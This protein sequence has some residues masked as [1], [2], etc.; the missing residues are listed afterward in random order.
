MSDIPAEDQRLPSARVKKLFRDS[1]ANQ[2]MRISG[3]AT[4]V[5]VDVATEFLALISLAAL[6]R[7]ERPKQYVDSKGVIQALIDM[8][9]ADLAEELPDLSSFTEDL[10]RL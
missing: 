6:D 4:D 1:F 8:G 10:Q 9:F 5:L 7:S 3:A 2:P